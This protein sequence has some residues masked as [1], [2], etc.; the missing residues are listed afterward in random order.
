VLA[1][2]SLLCSGW[3]ILVARNS[4]VNGHVFQQVGFLSKGFATM[5]TTERLLS[6]VGP[7][8]NLDVGL[9]EEPPVTYVTMMHHFLALV[10]L[11]STTPTS[12]RANTSGPK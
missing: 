9:V 10:P 8:M 5:I 11:S 12:S 4:F 2:S 3:S 6:R 7:Q 1:V